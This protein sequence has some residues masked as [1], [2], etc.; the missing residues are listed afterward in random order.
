MNITFLG[1]GNVGG[2]LAGHL[3]T[4]NHSVT[5]AA[6]NPDSDSVKVAQA[7]NPSLVAKPIFE[8]IC[9]ADVIFLATPYEMN[10]A[11]LKS[12]G[13]L[14]G[15]I[16][17]DCTN[18]VGPGLTHGLNST[19][20]GAE[21]VQKRVPEAKV[22]KA[23]TVYGFEN[24]Q[25]THYPGYQNGDQDLKPAMFIAGDDSAA[26]AMIG[27]LSKQLGWET[28]D[29]GDLSM[30]LHLEHMTLLWIKMARIQGQGAGFTWAKLSR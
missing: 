15:K 12:A 5:I 26:K 8:A 19:I 11:A 2:A 21:T 28:V 23:F 6:R 22:V 13:D 3:V 29:T 7:N 27:E 18:P 10:E 9:E 20:S 25:D 1:I 17:V 16:L 4:L 14:S 30:S 24:F